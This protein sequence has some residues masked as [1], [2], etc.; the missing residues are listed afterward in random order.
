MNY[1]EITTWGKLVDGG[2]EY[3]YAR[4]IILFSNNKDNKDDDTIDPT[5][6]NI[7]GRLLDLHNMETFADKEEDLL[8]VITYI[9]TVRQSRPYHIPPVIIC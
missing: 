8:L 7:Y 4:A 6:D 3:K 5:R 2:L 9:R 1:T